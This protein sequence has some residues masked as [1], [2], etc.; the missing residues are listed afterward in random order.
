MLGFAKAEP[1]PLLANLDY[2]F[3]PRSIAFLG[4]TE[5]SLKWGFLVFNNLLTGGYRGEIYPVNPGRESVMGLK[6][7]KSV[8]DIP[9][10]VDLAV[11]TVPAEHVPATMDDCA[12][13]GVKAA[14]VISAGF[15]ELGGQGAELERE[16]VRRARAGGIVL[17]GPN[18][19]GV[20]NPGY[21][22][23]PWM[24]LFYPPPGRVAFLSQSGNVL[25]MVISAAYKSG[26]GVSKAVSIGNEADLR[27][28]DY[29]AYFADDADTDVIVVY[30]EGTQDGR[31]FFD[32]ARE[33][34]PRKPV[35]VM[36]GGRTGTGIAAA[37]SHTG[38]MAVSDDFFEAACRQAGIVRARSIDE[39]GVLAASF[40]DRP[41]PRGRRV[42][43]VTGGGGL[44]VISADLCTAEG[45]EV[46]R[47]SE[48]TIAKVGEHLPSWW[49][50]GNPIDLV[51]GLD[52]SV[53]MP[54]IENL[55]LS[56]EVDA[57]IFTWVAALREPE[58]RMPSE[59]SRGIDL[60]D[61]WDKVGGDF[62]A[63]VPELYEPMRERQIPLYVISNMVRSRG[64][65]G[66]RAAADGNGVTAY[67]DLE[68]ACRALAEMARYQEWR[69]DHLPV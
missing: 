25:N 14:L 61:M 52:F 58:L 10:P 42:G 54:I 32:L 24:P 38:A 6:A 22:L 51:A 11:F 2:L 60:R 9:G 66:R 43:I 48:E 4:A 15:K 65:A 34:T 39:A 30:M 20:C 3:H 27:A 53:T 33:V 26:S 1:H 59:H 36:K 45:L 18:G 12:A 69:S 8:R 37:R 44:G 55:M 49:V 13:K 41:L 28:E 68:M 16:M 31:R 64:D 7:Y 56:G 50:P 21:D 40:V 57:I 63:R 5:F 47:L 35:I 17:A 23:F 46:V 67:N 62:V 29:L 19:Q